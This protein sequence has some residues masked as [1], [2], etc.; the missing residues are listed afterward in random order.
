MP[1]T[2]IF[3][4]STSTSPL[5]WSVAV[6]TVPFLISVRIVFYR[7]HEGTKN[8]NTHEEEQV[9]LLGFLRDVFMTSCLRG[10]ICRLL[11]PARNRH[12]LVR[13]ELNPVP[14]VRREVAEKAVLRAAERKV[15]H[16]RGHAD[17]HADHRRGGV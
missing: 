3:S 10:C 15:G 13:V 7:D 17:V 14:A 11:E 5:Y 8:T 16:R 12:F 4:S 6:T 9:S 1:M 2:A